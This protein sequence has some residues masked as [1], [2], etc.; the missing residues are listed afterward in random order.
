MANWALSS[1]SSTTCCMPKMLTDGNTL[2]MNRHVALSA[3]V[4]WFVEIT[5]LSTISVC[6]YHCNNSINQAWWFWSLLVRWLR[7]WHRCV[8]LEFVLRNCTRTLAN[9]SGQNSMTTTPT[10]Q[11]T[12]SS[13]RCSTNRC[14]TWLILQTNQQKRMW[15]LLSTKWNAGESGP[16]S[17]L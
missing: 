10:S 1:P 13:K 3:A 7:C 2:S 17:Y 14:G 8:S 15:T 6:I 4:W 11:A 16:S 9:E 12:Q 5:A